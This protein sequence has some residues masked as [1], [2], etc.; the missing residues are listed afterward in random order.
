MALTEKHQHLHRRNG[1]SK[2]TAQLQPRNPKLPTKMTLKRPAEM[3]ITLRMPKEALLRIQPT[4]KKARKMSLPSRQKLSQ[5][6]S[7]SKVQLLLTMKNMKERHK[8]TNHGGGPSRGRPIKMHSHLH[9]GNR[10][11]LPLTNI[12]ASIDLD[13]LTVNPR[14]SWPT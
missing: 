8:S 4:S 6:Q 12:L 7:Q 10:Q 5:G 11:N 1:N 13:D 9:S 14:G 2:M 3:R